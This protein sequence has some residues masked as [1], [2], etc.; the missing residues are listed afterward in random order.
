VANTKESWP[1]TRNKPGIAR[2]LI[3][4][5][6]FSIQLT[7]NS[8]SADRDHYYLAFAGRCQ[9]SAVCCI[10]RPLK[11]HYHDHAGL[12]EHAENFFSGFSFYDM[13]S[14]SFTPT[15]GTILLFKA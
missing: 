6:L 12:L 4:S 8:A 3:L 11:G 14:G 9:H 7:K 15:N 5:I 1:A 10:Y 13:Q 2:S